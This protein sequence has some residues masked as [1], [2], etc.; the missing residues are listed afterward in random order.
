LITHL[1]RVKE[2]GMI[3]ALIVID[4][5]NDY[6]PGGA[7]ELVGAEAAA[8]NAAKAIASCRNKDVPVIHIQHISVH[9]GAFF[10]LPDTPGAEIQEKV[11]PVD[12]EKVV[13]KHFPNSFRETDLQAALDEIGAKHVGICG[14]MTHMCVDAT[15][16]AAFDAGLQS[17]LLHDACATRDLDFDGQKA[18]AACVQTSFMS[19]LAFAYADVI[20]TEYFLS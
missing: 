13:L 4:I 6:F 17:T 10:F 3:D 2:H 15:T 12:G 7:M 18:T 5:Q 19:A 11:K 14:M 8:D 16:R 20:G 1:Q 9:P